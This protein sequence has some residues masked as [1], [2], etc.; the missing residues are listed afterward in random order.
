MHSFVRAEFTLPISGL[1]QLRISAVR[2]DLPRCEHDSPAEA[3][4]AIVCAKA[5]PRQEQ[6]WSSFALPKHSGVL[7]D[8]PKTHSQT[9]CSGHIRNYHCLV[10]CVDGTAPLRD[11]ELVQS[12]RTKPRPSNHRH[13]PAVSPH[14]RHSSFRAILC[15]IISGMEIYGIRQRA[16]ATRVGVRDTWIYTLPGGVLVHWRKTP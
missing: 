6:P 5:L 7:F 11:I 15:Y 14:R 8:N 4:P 10:S 16:P 12:S 3:L 1:P 2:L 9:S 13:Q